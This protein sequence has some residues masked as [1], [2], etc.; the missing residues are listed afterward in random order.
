MVIQYI[1]FIKNKILQEEIIN[2]DK[3]GKNKIK[4]HMKKERKAVFLEELDYYSKN[5]IKASE[6]VYKDITDGLFKM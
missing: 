1:C 3:C 5:G 4:K 2:C 6:Y